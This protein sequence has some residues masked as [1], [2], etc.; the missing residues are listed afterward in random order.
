MM[1]NN[2][3]GERS[4]SKLN[5]IIEELRSTI[6]QK[7]LNSLSLMSI[8]HELLSSLEYEN[9]IEDCKWKIRKRNH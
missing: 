3:S 1:I 4:F 7:R 9:V 5:L 6:S 2:C 8:D